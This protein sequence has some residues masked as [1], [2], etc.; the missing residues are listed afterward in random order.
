[1]KFSTQDVDN[2]HLQ[3]SCAKAS[4]GAWWYKACVR[5]H[6][7]GEYLRGHHNQIYKGVIW[8]D[9]KG[10]KYSYKGAEMKVRRDEN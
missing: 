7:N 6:L 9:F 3:A 1:M 4:Q 10:N 5:S 2:D 8:I